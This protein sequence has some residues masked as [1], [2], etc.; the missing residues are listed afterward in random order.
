MTSDLQLGNPQASIVIDRER[1]ASLGV[2]AQQIESALYNAY[3]SR[4]VSTIYAPNN[5]YWV[6][7]ELL[8]EYQR[9]LSALSLLHVRSHQGHDG[10]AERGG[11]D[12]ADAPGR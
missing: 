10:A 6:V 11:D 12:V 8:P 7:M 5:E 2:T 9:D 3:G 4:Q 1:A